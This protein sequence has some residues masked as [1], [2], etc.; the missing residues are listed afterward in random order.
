MAALTSPSDPEFRRPI[1]IIS[2]P[3]SGSTLLFET[4]ARSKNLF[5]IGGES[6]RLI[7]TIPELNVASH[8]LDSNRLLA[9][10]ATP[11]VALALRAN[12]LRS[13][14]DRD[15][16]TPRA[17]PTRML[18]KTPKNAL[19]IPFLRAVFPEAFFIILL[20]SPQQTMC[21]MLEAWRSG[22]FQTY[23]RFPGWHLPSWSLVLT[24]GWRE[25]VGKSLPEI[26]VAQWQ[27]CVHLMM[28][29]IG[30]VP[31]D[32]WLAVRYEDLS[33]D[34]PSVVRRVCAELG[35]EWDSPLHGALPTSRYTVSKPDADKWLQTVNEI[36]PFFQSI[37]HTLREYNTFHAQAPI[38]S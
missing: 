13:L 16:R 2:P 27:A 34:W 18:E 32:R 15:G 28:Q 26:V 35:L 4:L 25:L 14:H 19:R 1:F 9:H 6:H 8:N 10:H 21:S 33:S 5:T 38:P 37:D 12:F 3:R 22:R 20:R 30:D 31:Q 11:E 29:D 24:P 17:L 36:E 23:P 7:E